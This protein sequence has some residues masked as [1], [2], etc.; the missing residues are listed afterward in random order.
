MKHEFHALTIAEVRHET[1]DAISYGLNV[2]DAVRD[3]FRFRPGQHITVRA[4]IGSDVVE[5]TYSISNAPADRLLWITIKLTHGGVFSSWAHASL[6]AGMM[7]E[8]TPPAGRFTLPEKDGTPRRIVGIAAGSGITPIMGI[9]EHALA[10]EPAAHVSLLY[11]N[12]SVD[13]I[14]FRTRLEHLKDLHLHRLQVFHVLSRDAEADVPVLAGRIDGGKIRALL[15]GALPG[16]G[17]HVFL[18]GPD[19][20]IKEARDT[21]LAL[22]VPRTAIH[23]EFFKQ[24]PQ[25]ATAGKPAQILARPASAGSDTEVVAV[26]DGVRKTFR[27]PEG[28]HIIDAALAAGIRLPYSCKGGMCCTCRAKLV[29]GEV[30]MDRNFSL[31]AW[32]MAAGFVLTCQARPKTSRLVLDYDQM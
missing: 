5:R 21:L 8:T 24:G 29:D 2:P 20:L 4:G 13:Q 31:E 12:R 16:S 17:D 11:G 15:G 10:D 23:F 26:L 14:I 28:V 30:T 7:I 27:V 32:E 25:A 19:S 18:C 6:K 9:I 3:H 22:G 1:S